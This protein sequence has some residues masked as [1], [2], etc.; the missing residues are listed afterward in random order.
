MKFN[1]PSPSFTPPFQAGE[2]ALAHW[3]IRA[4][5]IHRVTD[6]VGDTWTLRVIDTLLKEAQRFEAL[7]QGLG[8]PRSTLSARL[9]LLIESGCLERRP[10]SGASE[11]IYS[12]TTQGRSL[13]VLLRQMQQWNRRW[14][15]QGLVLGA[16]AIPNPCGHDADLHL[17][18]GH[19][20][21]EADP[22]HM[23]VL[24]T[25]R[26][27][28]TPPEPS[29]KRARVLTSGELDA[30]L[31]AEQLMG[32]RWTGLILGAAFFRAQRFSDI[33]Q[34][35]GIATNVLATRLGRLTRQGLMHRVLE[36]ASSERHIYRLT[37]RGLSYYPV[38]AAALAWGQQWL[39]PRYDP[40][41]RV[42][43]ADCLTWFEP[44]FVCSDCGQPAF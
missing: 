38:I 15:V 4:N 14:G 6:L 21:G 24:Q 28:P 22:R 42:L 9:R 11:Q 27:P 20:M 44:V 34:A 17:R 32:D 19:C 16:S 7:V 3:M 39:A 29:L 1:A 31:P 25:H 13:L 43:H 12:L 37:S 40:G 18:C 5:V 2:S 10:V 26:H 30:P 36:G 8:I 33:E 41:W 23:K 35:L